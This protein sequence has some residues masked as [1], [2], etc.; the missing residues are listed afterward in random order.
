MILT[1]H[2]VSVLTG[3]KHLA[4]V[5]HGV[6]DERVITVFYARGI[7][8]LD[9]WNDQ[10]SLYDASHVCDDFIRIQFPDVD[11]IPYFCTLAETRCR[12]RCRGKC[13]SRVRSGGYPRYNCTPRSPR[14]DIR[15]QESWLRRSPSSSNLVAVRVYHKPLVL[16]ENK[17][18]F[19]NL[20]K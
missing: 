8:A 5:T 17:I 2:L 15:Y 6:I 13:D 3:I 12:N 4:E 9:T 20:L 7:T 14:L 16:E 1:G 11:R 18:I 19:I 10:N